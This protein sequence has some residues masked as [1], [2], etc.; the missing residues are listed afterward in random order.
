MSTSAYLELGGTP[1][2]RWP[3]SYNDCIL[4]WCPRCGADALQQCSNPESGLKN[5]AKVKHSVL[6]RRRV[7]ARKAKGKY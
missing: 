6:K 3:R 2:V 1:E 5:R 7:R 4:L